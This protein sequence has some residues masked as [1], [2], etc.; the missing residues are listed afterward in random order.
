MAHVSRL[1]VAFIVSL[2]AIVGAQSPRTIPASARARIFEEVQTIETY[3]FS[4]PNR[5]PILVRDPRLYPYHSFEGYAHERTPQKWNVVH[6]ENDLIEVFV[7]PQIGGK[8]WGARVRKTGHEFIYRNE[9]VKFRNIALR[10]PWTSGGIEFNFGVIGHTPSTATPVD[11]VVKEN[12]DGSVSCVVGAMDLPS[13]TEWRVEVRLPPDKAAFQT[14]VLWHNPTTQ[15]QPYYNWMTAAAFARNDLEMSM[16][17]TAYLQHSGKRESWPVDEQGHVLPVYRNNTF[18]DNKSFHVV[19]ELQHFFGG[20]YHDAGYGFGHWARHE[21]MPGQKLWLWALSRSGAIWEDLLTDT[22]GQYVEFQAGRLLVQYAP[23]G[24]VNPI[25]QAGFDPLA[26]DRWS[27]TWFPIEGLGGLTDASADGAMFIREADDHLEVTAHAFGTATDTLRIWSGGQ[28]VEDRPV[29]L[30]PLVRLTTQVPHKR[31]TPYRVEFHHLGLDYSSD[32]STRTLSRPFETDVDAR[33]T[34][35]ETDRLVFDARELARARRYDRAR[36]LLESALKLQ[37]WHRD[38]LLALADLE[39]RRAR[40]AEGL[41]HVTRVLRL[42]TYDAEAN[43]IAGNLYR[44][45]GRSADARDSFGWAARAMAYRSAA[46]VQLAELALGQSGFAEAERYARVALDYNAVNLSAWDLLAIV[47]RLTANQ[48]LATSAISKLRELN[49]LHHLADAEAYLSVRTPAALNELLAGIRGEYPDQTILELA[50]GYAARGRADDAVA[51]LDGAAGRLPNPLLGA[52]R[53][54][55]A[56]DPGRLP[57]SVDVAF[58]FP[59]RQETLP[60]L[61]WTTEQSP[62][63]TWKYL[64]A[65]NL[66]ALDRSKEADSILTSIGNKPD[67]APFYVARA[68]LAERAGRDPEQDLVQAERLAGTDRNIRIPLIRFYQEQRRWTDALTV[69]ARARDQFAGDFNLDLL[70]ARSLV[71]L[72]RAV[73]AIAILDKARVLP[74]ENA[75]DSHQLYVQAHVLAALSAIQARRLDEAYAHLGTALEWPEHLG[76]GRPYDPEE[77]LVRLILGRVEEQ[78]GRAEQAARSFEAVVAATKAARGA[79]TWL[80]LLAIP[81]LRSLGRAQEIDHLVLSRAS[82]PRT[83]ATVRAL[84]GALAN[85]TVPAGSGFRDLD[86]ELVTRALSLKGR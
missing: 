81:A 9:V 4:E 65:L 36:P 12:P 31:G 28:L 62:H 43:F 67:F 56:K 86:E 70:H 51:L 19:G 76:Q 1:V 59:Y 48:S 74:S 82:N 25:K 39:Y 21:D 77:R 49:P 69:S 61:Q 64:L 79:L 38:A 8:V 75:R 18:G 47:G 53:A 54:Y 34:I 46:N 63:W 16:P 41:S 42:D 78:R 11:Y 72:N 45:L 52:W 57:S 55:L 60:V 15:E 10:G 22:D 85:G 24:E 26:T 32:L 73:E 66:W 29:Q 5:V 80:D 71:N 84:A 58:V 40:Y 2:A 3:P 27:E 35:A 30:E 37:P 83:D 50:I 20:Y 33:P 7:L 14:N 68:F 6:L 17:G 13:R 23:G 44:A